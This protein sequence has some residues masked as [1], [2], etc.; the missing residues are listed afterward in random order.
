L[1]PQDA[2]FSK[3]RKQAARKGDSAM[4]ILRLAHISVVVHIKDH[5]GVTVVVPAD[6]GSDEALSM[7]RLVLTP[8][9]HHELREAIATLPRTAPG[10]C[11]PPSD[12]AGPP[13]SPP[14]RA[15]P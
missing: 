11:G 5:N 2:D 3:P 4:R 1:D 6:L 13:G 10:A 7:A 9:E 12:P 8:K 15:H 14:P